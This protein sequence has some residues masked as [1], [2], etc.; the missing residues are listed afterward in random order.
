MYA[1][2]LFVHA[3]AWA[4]SYSNALTVLPGFSSEQ[5][6]VVAGSAAAE[7]ANR[8]EKDGRWINWQEIRFVCVEVK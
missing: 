8:P 4:K 6:C 1:L 7:L 3:S 5:A 2:I